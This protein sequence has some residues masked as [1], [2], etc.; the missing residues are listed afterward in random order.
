MTGIS[1]RLPT[2]VRG[3]SAWSIGALAGLAGGVIEVGWITLYQSLAGHDSAAVARGVTQS[4]IPELATTSAAVPLGVAIH[5]ALAVVLGIV[6][7][8][9]VRTLLPRVVGTTMEPVAVVGMLVGVWAANFL[10]I[11]PAINPGFV[12]LVPYGASLASKVLFGFAAAFVFWC[13]SRSAP[14]PKKAQKETFDVQ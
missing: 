12:A 5:M 6:I 10:V 13:V 14:S 1:V 9:L 2:K 8:L 11:L 3:G 4:L 7:A